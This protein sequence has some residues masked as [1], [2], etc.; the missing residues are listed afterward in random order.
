MT[1]AQLVAAMA[2]TLG[3]FWRIRAGIAFV[4]N[5]KDSL[6]NVNF[7]YA[8]TGPSQVVTLS[9]ES[10]STAFDEI[11]RYVDNSHLS[12]DIFLRLVSHLEAF[13]SA[14]L[15][16]KGQPP[17]GTLGNLQSRCQNAYSVQASSAYEIDEIRERR[18][19][20]IHHGGH[21]TTKYITAAAK[22]FQTSGG[23]IIDPAT[24]TILGTS[25]R[26]L[27]HCADKIADYSRLF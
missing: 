9:Q 25:D 3:T 19:S 6:P 23:A 12:K 4:R 2:D 1:S 8:N 5:S 20:I 10:S 24:A 27:N 7:S 15:L 18:N 26:Y 11:F 21:P 22:V 14:H 13:Y 17:E 16:I